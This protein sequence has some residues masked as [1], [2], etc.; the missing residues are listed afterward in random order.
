MTCPN[1]SRPARR[2]DGRRHERTCPV[3]IAALAVACVVS[4]AVPAGAQIDPLIGLKRLPPRVIVIFDTSLPMLSDGNN[5]LYDLKTYQRDDDPAVA[6]ALGVTSPEYRRIYRGL[7]PAP[8]GG[9]WKY[10]AV[11]ITAIP[12][13]TPAVR[14]LLGGHAI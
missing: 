5:D 14:G 4:A 1:P 11:D 10:E 12:S 2:S 6:D 7:L 3:T 9:R 13:G 8:S